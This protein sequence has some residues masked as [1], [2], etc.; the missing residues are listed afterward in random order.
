MSE[1]VLVVVPTYNGGQVWQAS[2]TALAN[3]VSANPG[4][5]K[6]QVV[7]SA[8]SDD[9]VQVARNMGFAVNIIDG[10]Q[11]DHGGTRNQVAFDAQ[12]TEIVI[13]LTQD[14][15]LTGA[16]ALTN[17]VQ[18]FN[19][20]LVVVAYGRQLPH[21]NANP[22]ASHARLFNYPDK[23]YV[24]GLSDKATMGLK[25]V[26]T[27]NSF[28]AYRMS[29][30]RELGGFPCKTILSEDMYFASRAVLAGYRV[31]YVAQACVQHSHNYSPLEEF[32]RYFDIGVFQATE[33]WI[34]Q[35]FG[36]AGGEGRRFLMSEW[37][38][39]R[40][41]APLWVLRAWLHD[42]LKIVGYKLGKAYRYLPAAWCEHFSMN[43]RYWKRKG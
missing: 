38:Y 41:K 4:R 11:F 30:F 3:A 37:Q 34:G 9:S 29:V 28:A 6:V 19:D 12:S 18:A 14:A 31:A 42:F 5:F 16:D 2:A 25:A 7:D 27:S 24:A 1:P 43:R 17:L 35:A 10:A 23:S 39:L 33:S 20:P 21:D 13:F 32:R 22:I 8:S 40:S 26:F 36:G 15:V